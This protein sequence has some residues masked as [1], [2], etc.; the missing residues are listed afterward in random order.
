MLLL[1]CHGKLSYVS[2]QA[3][4]FLELIFIRRSIISTVL[5]NGALG[6][7]MSVAFSF[8]TTDPEAALTS[9]TGYDFIYVFFAG[10]QSVAGTSLMS[11]VLIVL[12]TCASFGFLASTSRQTWAFARDRGLPY[13]EWLVYVCLYPPLKH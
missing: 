2:R 13:S 6:F 3:V 5:L 9:P 12:V 7:A 4:D 11:A 1:P 8:C 10:N